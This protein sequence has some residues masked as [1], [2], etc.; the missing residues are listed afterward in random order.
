MNSTTLLFRTPP[1][2]T[3]TTSL[4]APRT[5]HPSLVA[6]YM[7]VVV[8]VRLKCVWCEEARVGMVV[9]LLDC[10][11]WVVVSEVFCFHV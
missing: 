6:V 9:E 4:L 7:Y 2:P 1:F 5:R 10:R 3:H 11:V 8:V